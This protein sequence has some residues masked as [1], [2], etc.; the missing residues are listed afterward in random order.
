MHCLVHSGEKGVLELLGLLGSAYGYA[1]PC[2]DSFDVLEIA[3]MFYILTGVCY[4][5]LFP[6]VDFIVEI[7]AV[8]AALSHAEVAI[9]ILVF[10][11][12]ATKAHITTA[13]LSLSPYFKVDSSRGAL[14]LKSLRLGQLWRRHVHNG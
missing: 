7:C 3:L 5:L 11:I 10:A 8:E 4:F 12:Y 13:F 2:N 9:P 6:S 14:V 1:S